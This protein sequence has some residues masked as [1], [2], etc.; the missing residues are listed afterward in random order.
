MII[1]YVNY[2]DR[3]FQPFTI[4]KTESEPT[5]QPHV[6]LALHIL[7]GGFHFHCFTTSKIFIYTTKFSYTYIHNSNHEVDVAVRTNGS[8]VIHFGRQDRGWLR[9]DPRAKTAPET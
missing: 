2:L 1:L 5:I 3:K 7:I 9:D 4:H 6:R 8:A